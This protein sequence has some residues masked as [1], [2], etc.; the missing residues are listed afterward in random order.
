MVSSGISYADAARLLGGEAGGQSRIVTVLDALTGGALLGTVVAVPAVLGLFDAA[1]EFVRLSHELVRALSERRAGLSRYARTE[2]LAAAHRV[3]VVTAFFET[4]AEADLPFR[5]RDLELT[6]REQVEIAGTPGADHQPLLHAFFSAGAA[7]PLSGPQQPYESFRAE[8]TD[9]YRQVSDRFGR[10]VVGLAA[11]DFLGVTDQARFQ[12]VLADLPKRAVARHQELLGRLAGDFPEV[13][14]WAGLREHAA[15]RAEVRE[16]ADAFAG[17]ERLLVGISTGRAPDDRRAG[18]ARAAAAELDR[19]VIASGEVPA[20]LRVPTLGEAYLPHRYRLAEVTP[21]DRLSD[22]S[23][24]ADR[25]VR[26][27]LSAFLAGFLTAPGVTAA[28]LLVLGQPGSG[29]SV[30][31]RVLAARLPAADFLPVRVVLRDV[32]AAAD[33][34]DQIEYAVRAATG[35]RLDWPALARSAGDAL[36]VVLLDGFDELLQATG[37]SQTDYLDRVAAFSAG[38]PI[39]A[40]RWWSW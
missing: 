6:K 23:W 30:L 36:P 7:V 4:L 1:V 24:W 18:L 20:G 38:R 21:G 19:P 16:L 37:V 15:T 28:P 5:F 8:L 26:D 17:L 25:L 3:I 22:E 27:D 31:T 29:K 10:F 13:A 39:R 32:P 14:F 11:W 35:E 34:Q 2:R 33:L 40:G 9:Y 12:A